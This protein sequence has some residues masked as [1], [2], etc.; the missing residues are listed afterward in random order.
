MELAVFYKLFARPIGATSFPRLACNSGAR[1]VRRR[2][3]CVDH[4]AGRLLKLLIAFCDKTTTFWSIHLYGFGI[5]MKL[6]RNTLIAICV[7]RFVV[8]F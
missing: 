3:N 8:K 5:S 1:V 2:R 4:T 7:N 6:A